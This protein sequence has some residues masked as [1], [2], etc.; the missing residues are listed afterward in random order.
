MK[1]WLSAVLLCLS[2][3]IAHAA[4]V[5]FVTIPADTRG[6]AVRA[7]IWTPCA[8]P[9]RPLTIGPFVLQGQRDCPT[10]G[11]KLPLVVISHGHGGTFLGHHDLAETLADAGYVVAAINHPGDTFFDMSRAADLSD[12]VE[13]PADIKRLVDYMLDKAPDAARIDATRIGFFGF[14]RGGYTGLVLA[15]ANPDF[16]HAAL[17]CPDPAWPICRQIRAG[18]V[19]TA[20][21]THDPRI[22]AYVLA[23]PFDAFPSAD[24]LKDVHA[25]IQ[26]WASE[27]GGDGVAPEMAPALAALLPQRPEFHVVPNAAHFAF[28]APCPEQL[29]R[30]APDI[31]TDATG[32]DRAAFHRTLDAKALAFFNANLR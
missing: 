13:R 25:P 15:G 10:A 8:A 28:L 9:A 32:F 29:A 14:S 17:A 1:T 30:N 2:A 6:P 19:P 16:V 31:C 26:L 20:P 21:L 3:T 23:D 27:A 22:K 4:G 18:D 7:A 11:D 24:T 12:F 5:K